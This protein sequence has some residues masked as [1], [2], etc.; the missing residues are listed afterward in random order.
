MPTAADRAIAALRTGHDDLASSVVTMT[1]EDLGRRSGADEWT[2]AQVLSHLGSGAE[3]NL[4]TLRRSLERGAEAEPDANQRVWDRW[5]A[6]SP[7]DQAAGFLQANA[8]LL[9]AYEALDEQ[10]RETARIDLGFLPQPVDVAT[11]AR[12]RLNEFAL[13]A[14]DI[15]VATD[16]SATVAQDAAE[17]LLDMIPMTLGWIAKPDVLDGREVA[18][19]VRLTD[20]GRSYVLRLD[21]RATLYDAPAGAADTTTDPA[22]DAATDAEG[23]TSRGGG[24]STGATLELP[25]EAWLRLVTG[26]LRPD[27]TPASVRVDGAITLDELRQVFPGF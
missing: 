2:V 12:F 25:A 11:A 26:R 14:W 3:I 16:P 23:G 27:H 1:P 15:R 7:P 4:A 21:D 22:S 17:Q 19:A 18:I 9:D 13:H 5:N 10:T 24:G 20:I 6:M 8:A